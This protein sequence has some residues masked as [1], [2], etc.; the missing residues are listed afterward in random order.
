[1]P[2][3]PWKVSQRDQGNEISGSCASLYN[4]ARGRRS[5]LWPEP[6]HPHSCLWV[7]YTV[8]RQHQAQAVS[9]HRAGAH[10]SPRTPNSKGDHGHTTHS[11]HAQA[12]PAEKSQVWAAVLAWT[13]AA[14][15]K[16][17]DVSGLRKRLGPMLTWQW[18]CYSWSVY[19]GCKGKREKPNKLAVITLQCQ[20]LSN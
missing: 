5:V 3:F 13:W 1:M 8:F 18:V 19:L 11:K 12:S 14:A 9:W 20:R 2:A 6:F 10:S 16:T 15:A 17:A 4:H 7:S